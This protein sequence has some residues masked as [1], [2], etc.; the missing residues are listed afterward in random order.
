MHR[1]FFYFC[2]HCIWRL[3]CTNYYTKYSCI[4]D[5]LNEFVIPGYNQIS[6]GGMIASYRILT[7]PWPDLSPRTLE[8]RTAYTK[9]ILL[10]T[11]ESANRLGSNFMVGLCL[12]IFRLFKETKCLGLCVCV[13]SAAFAMV[14]EWWNWSMYKNILQ[15]KLHSA[16]SSF[17]F[18]K[19]LSL[20]VN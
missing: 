13:S 15:C 16:V 9:S 7:W 2:L 1:L 3:I 4:H 14:K 20:P 17:H 19:L 6:C 18:I 12:V 5:G 11:L 10:L 8:Q